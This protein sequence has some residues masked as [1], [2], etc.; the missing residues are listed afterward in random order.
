VGHDTDRAAERV[1]RLDRV[2]GS[3]E[4]VGDRHAYTVPPDTDLR[5]VIE[6]LAPEPAAPRA[7][8][9]ARKGTGHTFRRRAA[10]VT[11]GVAGP[12]G[13]REW[14]CI[15]LARPARGFVDEVLYHGA[16]VVLLEPGHLRDQ[17]V[18]RLRAVVA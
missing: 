8:L 6:R 18:A 16:D 3:V 9:L 2:Q 15:E 13:S 1:F 11:D 10:S 14:D 17:V 7:V 5:A 4:L 12:D